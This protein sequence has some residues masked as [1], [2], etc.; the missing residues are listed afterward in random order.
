MK[1]LLVGALALLAA[2][3][4]VGFVLAM[5]WPLWA[6]LFLA[7]L[8]VGAVLAC[9]FLQKLW[10]RNREHGFVKDVME[11]EASDRRVPERD[12]S[13]LHELQARWKQG[14]DALCSSQLK[15]LGNPL[16]VLPWYLM[17]GPS[18]SSK[19]T[20]L[21]SATASS[22][23]RQKSGAAGGVPTRNCDWWFLEQAVVIDTAGRYAVPLDEGNDKEEWRHFLRLL[24]KYRRREPLNGVVVTCA[25]DRLFM[26]ETETAAADGRAIRRRLDELMQALGV[27]FPVYVL[28]TK[29]DL[30]HGFNEF[31]AQLP[32]TCLNQPMGAIKEDPSQEAASFLAHALEVTSERLR[33]LRLHLLLEESA[34]WEPGRLLFPEEFGHLQAGLQAFM[35]AAFGGNHYQETPLLRGLFFSSG[36]QEGSPFSKF[37]SYLSASPEEP[38]PHQSERRHGA[39]LHDFFANILP[40][41][42]WL[43]AP[44][45][46]AIEWQQVTGNL[47]LLSWIILGTAI[48]GLLS[49]SFVKNLSTIRQI[50]HHFSGPVQS[51]TGDLAALDSYRQS[52]LAV[53]ERNRHWSMPRFG[54]NASMKVEQELKKGYCTKFRRSFLLAFDRQLADHMAAFPPADASYGEYVLHLARRINLLKAVRQGDREGALQAL[55]QPAYPG[56]LADA[57]PATRERFRAC[58]LSYLSWGA[59]SAEV[60]RDLAFWQGWLRHLVAVKGNDLSWM[61]GW[62]DRNGGSAPVTL[63]DFWGGSRRLAEERTVPPAFTRKGRNQL[64]G[65]LNELES[66][67]DDKQ[68]LAARR[69]GFDRWYRSTSQASWEAFVTGFARGSQRLKGE[70]EWQELAARMAGEK[71]PYFAL[72]HRL[73]NEFAGQFD[74]PDLPGWLQQVRQLQRVEKNCTVA[75]SQ[76]IKAAEGGKLLLFS[77]EK[78]LGRKAQ[79]QQMESRLACARALREYRSALAAIAP[80]TASRSQAYQAAMQLYM[81]DP[82]TSRSPFLTAYKAARQLQQAM[83]AGGSPGEPVGGL[84]AGPVDFLWNFVRMEASGY[85][86]SQWEEQVLGGTLGMDPQQATPLLLG[87]QGLV[88]R[89]VKGPAAPFLTRSLN[90]YHPKE[91]LGRC[92]QFDPGFLSFLEQG[93]HLQAAATGRQPSYNVG[94]EALPTDVNP[95]ARVKPQATRLELTCGAASQTLVNLN[96]PIGKTFSWSPDSCG[97]TL[98]QI[99]VGDLVLTRRYPGPQGFAQFLSSFPGGHHTFTPRDFPGERKSLQ[100]MGIRFIKLNYQ[101][102]GSELVTKQTSLVCSQVPRT[103]TRCWTE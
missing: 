101:F 38:P 61:A 7:L 71:S 33:S 6:A 73:E 21:N 18:G 68:F 34:E 22:P 82:A 98:L 79:A 26:E 42:R 5:D 57:G 66:A 20:S 54:L 13:E 50:S 102:T 52:I 29:C 2:L 69:A 10:F 43:V 32:D 41:D 67:L 78:K 8:L 51:G 44:T 30:I 64:N 58:Y 60:E 46:R 59:D 86:Q 81:D 77:L 63:A 11:Q 74:L 94:I 80:A 37:E 97:D 25:A 35:A 14:M 45:K 55:P 72:L 103:I 23:F 75:D 90:G 100:S 85:L 12:L 3:L 48:C 91:I 53:Q 47:G 15:K 16:Y 93:S 49:F 19:T 76:A 27:K 24:A 89:F 84:V 62:I 31:T 28:V 40:Q 96:Y 95:Q 65:L 87:P 36:H 9:L 39:F 88:W 17:I 4:V 56:D 70:R 1:L 99:E 83:A 92:V